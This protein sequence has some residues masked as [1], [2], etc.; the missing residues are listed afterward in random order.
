[1]NRYKGVVAAGGLVGLFA[2]LLVTLG[3]PDNMGFCIACFERD[4]AGALGLHRAAVVQYIRPEILGIVFGAMFAS[5]IFKE[6]RSEG[7]SAPLLRFFIGMVVMIGALAFLGCPLRM[8]LRL[9]GG[10]LNALTAM[11][12]FVS[13]IYAGVYFLKRGFNLDRSRQQHRYNAWILPLVFALLFFLLVFR[14]RFNPA[15]EGPIFFSSSGPGSMYAPVV[16]ALLAGIF[17]GFLSQRTRLCLMGGSR[18]VFLVRDFYLLSGFA[19]IFIVALAGNLIAGRFSIGFLNQ[20]AA[21]SEH[22]WNFLGMSVVGL[23]SVLLG[24]CPL[25]QLVLAGRGNSDS[26]LSV[27]GMIAGA[28]VAHNLNFAASPAGIGSWGKTAVVVSIAVL[29]LIAAGNR[30]I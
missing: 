17:T 12:G 23:G 19:A 10:D 13:G 9:A 1:M 14:V 16:I 6:F 28:A 29:L 27:L 30:E 15:G 4:I 26:S 2:V 24:G 18:D 7:G 8:V 3:N 11:A 21:H 5:F 22:L 25:R 20:P